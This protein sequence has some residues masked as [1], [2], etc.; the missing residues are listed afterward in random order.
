VTLLARTV[1]TGIGGSMKSRRIFI[2]HAAKD[3]DLADGFV[4]LLNTTSTSA[5]DIFCSS[6]EGLGVPSGKNFITYIR[7]QIQQPEVV[8]MLLTENYFA[9]Q[10]CLAELGAAWSIGHEALPLLVPPLTYNDVKGVLLSTQV[11]RIDNA[12][13]L[14]RFYD[15]LCRI[16]SPAHAKVARWTARKNTFLGRLPGILES[17]ENPETVSI[18]EH[19]QIKKKY[20]DALRAIE[21]Y[22]TENARLSELNKALEKLKDASKVAETKAALSGPYQALLGRFSEVRDLLGQLPTIVGYVMY[23]ELS[24]VDAKFDPWEDKQAISDASDAVEEGYLSFDD[25]FHLQES[26]PTVKSLTAALTKLERYIDRTVT[27]EVA[28]QFAAENRY[29][30]SLTNRR[31]WKDHLLPA[32]SRYT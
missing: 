10:F 9:S 31:L 15:E 27:E 30:L 2:S 26:D 22:E 20:E 16:L 28:D 32:I 23:R 18:A 17:L 3:K 4:E 19:G 11:D 14:D 12:N 24:G 1:I 5:D 25:S 29:Q 6:L 13:D 7:E 8:V 21:E